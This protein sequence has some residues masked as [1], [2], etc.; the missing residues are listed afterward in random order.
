MKM[1]Q[2]YLDTL[3]FFFRSQMYLDYVGIEQI[4]QI[5]D[6]DEIKDSIKRDLIIDTLREFG[7]NETSYRHGQFSPACERSALELNYERIHTG[8]SFHVQRIEFGVLNGKCGVNIS[9]N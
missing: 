4:L 1:E 7:L 2:Y 3:I 9:L 8:I 6:D 5:I